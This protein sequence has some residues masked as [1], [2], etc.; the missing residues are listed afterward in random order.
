MLSRT[1]CTSR[2]PIPGNVPLYKAE[3]WDKAQAAFL[4]EAI[5]EDSDWSGVVDQLDA[6]LR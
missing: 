4:K 1:F 2:R 6:L 3:I 5:E